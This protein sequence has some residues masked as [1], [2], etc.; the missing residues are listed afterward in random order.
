MKPASEAKLKEAM[1]GTAKILGCGMPTEV[2][3][4]LEDILKNLNGIKDAEC[5]SIQQN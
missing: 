1:A 4:I 5:Q 2:R 3:V